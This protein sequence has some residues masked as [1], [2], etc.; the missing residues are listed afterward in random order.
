MKNKLQLVMLILV[1]ACAVSY[2][3]MALNG[4]KVHAA[5]ALIWVLVVFFSDLGEYLEK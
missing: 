3:I 5:S 1:G 4:E 2:A